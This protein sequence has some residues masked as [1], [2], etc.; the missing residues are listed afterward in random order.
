MEL[1]SVTSWSSG[2]FVHTAFGEELLA[3]KVSVTMR[4]LFEDPVLDYVLE[5]VTENGLSKKFRSV[6][7]R[8]IMKCTYSD[9]KL[10]QV[11][12]SSVR[13]WNS[14]LRETAARREGRKRSEG[15]RLPSVS[16]QKS[17]QARG[18]AERGSGETER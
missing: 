5:R 8:R 1:L 7:S 17:Q 9:G 12:G 16:G 3:D 15:R 14:F 6:Q 18:D 10:P 2:F 13:L 4:V 11:N